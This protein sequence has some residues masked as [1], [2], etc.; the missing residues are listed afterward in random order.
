MRQSHDFP[1]LPVLTLTFLLFLSFNVADC[2]FHY[3]KPPAGYVVKRDDDI[4]IRGWALAIADT[5]PDGT[6]RCGK[7]SCCPYGSYCDDTAD[8]NSNFCCPSS[9]GCGFQL[10]LD[11]RCADVTWTLWSTNKD[12]ICCL[13]GQ[14]GTQPASDEYYGRCVPGLSAVAQSN[15]ATKVT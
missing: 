1:Y 13:A 6:G 9:L 8:T 12:P 2:A 3:V 7:A 5:C 14:Q 4:P 15:L 11:S 10:A